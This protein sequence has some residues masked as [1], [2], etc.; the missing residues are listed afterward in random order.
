MKMK[1]LVSMFLAAVM[2][3][4]LAG[5]SSGNS[6]NGTTE[7]KTTGNSTETASDEVV[8]INF[9]EHSDNEVAAQQLVD[10]YNAQST[11]V[12]V[13]LS[14]I[15][16][17]DYDDKV[18]VMLSGGGDIDCF[19][20]RGGAQTRQ[21]AGSNALLSLN[22]L[23]SANDIATDIYGDMGEAFTVDGNTYGLCTTKSCWLLWYNKDLFDAAGIDYP[24]NLTWEEYSELALSLTTD[25]L[26]GSVCP[27]WT[28]NLGATAV[29][30]YLTDEE[31]TRT[32]EYAEYL[33]RWYVTEGS[34]LSLEEMPASFDL[35]AYYAEGNTYMMINGDWTFLNFPE[36]DPQF[37]WCAA[38]LPIFEDAEAE[39][40]VGST[41]CFAISEKSKNPEAAFDFI[42]FAC[43]SDDGASIWAQNSLV[44]AYSSDAALEVYQ[45]TVTVPGVEYV[46]SANVGLEQGLDTNYEELNEAFKEELKDSLVGNGTLESAFEKYKTRRDEINAK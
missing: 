5:C 33:E 25:E 11:N 35:N 38:P 13:N 17:E 4:S 22:D 23:I 7:A 32:M 15:A 42:Q 8:E 28:M 12:K 2:V 40:T 31:L 19:W 18:K 10:A 1:K 26:M 16:N 24:I 20:I 6:G 3:V 29:G 46:F 37:E 27:D 36:Y 39:S 44:P 30:E 43:Y 21:L 41:S 14:I 34:H 45:E 9:Y